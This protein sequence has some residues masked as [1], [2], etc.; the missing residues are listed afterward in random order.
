MGKPV[1]RQNH[2]LSFFILAMLIAVCTAWSFYEEYLGRR[3]WK[4][5]QAKNSEYEKQKAN[6]DLRFV[7]RRL[8][9][10]D[11]KVV[12]DPARP[13]SAVTVTE[14]RK[15]LDAL[16]QKIA[17]DRESVGG[18]KNEL[19]DSEI[20]ASD[21][22]LK[23]KVLRSEDDGLFYLQQHAQHQEALS[24]TNRQKL[25][26][27][28]NKSGAEAAG[29]EAEEHRKAAAAVTEKRKAKAADIK[30]AM[31]DAVTATQKLDEVKGR[32]NAKV[33]E[34]DRLSVSIDAAMDP[35]L[36][37]QTTLK[38]VAN[39]GSE[40]TQ[41]WL[42]SYDNSVD[43]CQNCHPTVDK[44]GFS[45][46]HE[47][48]AA[49]AAPDAKPAD[50]ATNY[51]VNPDTL[52]SFKATADAVCGLE[53]DA[54]ASEKGE[55]APDKGRCF[56]GGENRARVSE[57]L[58]NYCGPK[59]QAIEL[60]GNTHH[61]VACLSTASFTTL[62]S[63]VEDP[64]QKAGADGKKW[65]AC[66]LQLTAT[67]DSCV[68]GANHDHLQIWLKAHCPDTSSTLKGLSQNKKACASG[69]DGKKLAEIKPV[70]YD[71]PLWAQTHPHRNELIGSNHPADRFGCTSCHEGQGAQTKGVGGQP[72]AHGYD[73]HYWDRPML[74]LVAHKKFRPTSWSA[75]K[76][77]EG[78]P[79]E[80]VSHQKH[81][82]E[83]TCAKCHV[84]DVSLP[85]ADTYSAGRRL[86]AELSCHGCH[87]MDVFADYPK[88]GPTLT[89]LK[90]KTTPEFLMAWL[91]YPKAFRPRT[92]M[93]N[94]WPEALDANRKVREG[95]PEAQ[96]RQDE[97]TRIAA[98][99]W[100][101]SEPG[102][103]PA[104]PV[105]GNAEHGKLLVNQVGCRGCH[106]FG[107][108]EKLCTPEQIA[109]GKSRGTAAV[110]G[111]CEVARSLSSSEARDFAPN[112][113]KIGVKTNERWLFAWL[114]NP[115]AMWAQ[116]R[117]PNLRLSD[118]DAADITAYLLTLK[119]G[120]ELAAQPFF[121]NDTSSDFDK[122]AEEG[123][124]L[125]TKYG[126]PGCHEIKGHEN[127]A[128][129]GAEMNEYG[130]KT[131]D[132]LDFG[133]AIPNPRHH[134]W[135]NFV[136]LKLR[137]PRVYRYERVET[138]MAQYD[139]NDDEVVKVMTFL[140]SR[141]AEKVPPSYLLTS[142]ER[143]TAMAHGEQTVEYYNCKGCHVINGQGGWVRDTYLEDDL[144]KAPPI[145][146]AEGWR[147]QPDWLFGF[148]R[149]PSNKLRPWLEIRMPTFP[150]ADEQATSLVKSFA[151][152]DKVP[153]PYVSVRVTP[154]QGAA[155]DE[156]KA[157]VAELRCYA[158][159]TS[160]EPAPGQDR[161]S[162]APNLQLA[163]HRLRPDW[164]AAWLKNPQSLQEGTK[165]PSFFNPDDFTSAMYPKYFGGSQEKQIEMIRDYI[166]TL[167][168]GPVSKPQ[169]SIEPGMVRGKSKRK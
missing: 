167:P 14:A 103:L 40:L 24:E 88:V 41:Y 138:R 109:A 160:G 59:L 96:L 152:H 145:L 146:Q 39:K 126:C 169:A 139:V 15:Q 51:C 156:T 157:M 72:F 9:S 106:T 28:G 133:N 102:N 115:S 17:A 62:A 70:L 101:H 155:M 52:D 144:A 26:T 31:V 25:E 107:P 67:G 125:I 100:K 65:S 110:P 77:N 47:V 127:D 22:D 43:R 71:L 2:S 78:V 19:K 27:A 42:T 36:T 136:D 142:N 120:G 35:V 64:A 37:A 75:P 10:G 92:K 18:L 90:K 165:M 56:E 99:L 73:D 8:E 123:G 16:N 135:Y 124:K 163:K 161:S 20:V 98:Y 12:L 30:Q 6:L 86:V 91:P 151:A 53:W 113:S 1:E 89:N 166:M 104:L 34:R 105:Q 108:L 114:K 33:G 116:T 87:P 131:V 82:T 83:S 48:L 38:T 5:V 141:T 76:A 55:I 80:W 46:P 128:K 58:L 159:H 150:F 162:L 45:R 119:D 140:K 57:F 129:I 44:C 54:E 63:Y 60:L 111:E 61:K 7:E 117:M 154:P 74:D 118:P 168:D 93:P 147:V 164:V 112:L 95:S 149:D 21:A 23:V 158:C 29:H 69:E 85:Y 84:D 97:A 3:P 4:D 68:E 153:F 130:R 137:A 32:M 143:L 94:F 148:L 134:S 49:L 121:A 132:L 122:A 66:D 79:G 11:I 50:V 13:D 81:F